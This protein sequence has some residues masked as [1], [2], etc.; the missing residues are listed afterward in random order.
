LK[1][2]LWHLTEVEIAIG[3]YFFCD[4]LSHGLYLVFN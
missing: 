1:R 4:Q 3:R 2:T